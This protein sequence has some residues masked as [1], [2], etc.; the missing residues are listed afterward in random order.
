[1][2]TKISFHSSQKQVANNRSSSGFTIVELMVVTAIIG[3]LS[4]LSIS[5]YQQYTQ[6]AQ[7][8]ELRVKANALK[9]QVELCVNMGRRG[10]DCQS[11][12]TGQFAPPTAIAVTDNIIGEGVAFT[13]AAGSGADATP[14]RYTITI[15][16]ANLSRL[17]T[18]V[19]ADVT[20]LL[21]G[22]MDVNNGNFIWTS[23]CT[24]V[25]IAELCQ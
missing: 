1:M 21:T 15:T 14:A 13:A 4:T 6:N 8:T 11:G 24:P 7:I 5:G 3:I 10:N 25:Q 22:E 12:G 16:A 20:F 18:S 9:K 19:G 2:T 17:R 23:N